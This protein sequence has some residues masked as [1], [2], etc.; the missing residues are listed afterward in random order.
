MNLTP[1]EITGSKGAFVSWHNKGKVP[2]RDGLLTLGSVSVEAIHETCK[3]LIFVDIN[4]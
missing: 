2:V 1:C 4:G 3:V